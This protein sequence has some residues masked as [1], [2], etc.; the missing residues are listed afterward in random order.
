MDRHAC[1]RD[2]RFRFQPLLLLQKKR[3]TGKVFVGVFFLSWW[4]ILSARRGGRGENVIVSFRAHPPFL[5]AWALVPQKIKSGGWATIGQKKQKKK[6]L[7]APKAI[8][9]ARMTDERRN[10]E[11]EKFAT[12]STAIGPGGRLWYTAINRRTAWERFLARHPSSEQSLARDLGMKFFCATNRDRPEKG[13]GPLDDQIGGWC[14]TPGWHYNPIR[15]AYDRARRYC[16]FTAEPERCVADLVT[17]IYEDED[18]GESH[19][20]PYLAVDDVP[21]IIRQ[22]GIAH[23]PGLYGAVTDVALWRA[24]AEMGGPIDAIASGNLSPGV[25][26]QWLERAARREGA[27]DGSLVCLREALP[28]RERPDDKDWR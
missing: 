25:R 20:V 5:F 9:T 15:L 17:T 24:T 13:G 28:L 12:E 6:G 8:I 7:E 23:L 27:S 19:P 16:K 2:F 21:K 14:R 1:R 18:D 4:G 3:E 11:A 26:R 10:S 22:C